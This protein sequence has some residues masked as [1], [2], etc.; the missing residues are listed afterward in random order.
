[1][2]S[3]LLSPKKIFELLHFKKIHKMFHWASSMRTGQKICMSE[4][5]IHLPAFS[6]MCK[7][8]SNSTQKSSSGHVEINFENSQIFLAQSPKIIC[9]ISKVSQK[10]ILAENFKK[11]R[12]LRVRGGLLLAYSFQ[13]KIISKTDFQR[14]SLSQFFSEKNPKI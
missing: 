7:Y 6:P 13:Q 3:F 10:Q 1:M 11:N 8:F 2:K 9:K 4:F 12:Y 14:S 5:P